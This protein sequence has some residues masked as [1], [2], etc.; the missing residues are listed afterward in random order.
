MKWPHLS[1]PLAFTLI[2]SYQIF[3]GQYNIEQFVF[4]AP[5]T[6]FFSANREGILSLIGHFSMQL[7]GVGMG[8][9]LYME[10]LDPRHFKALKANKTIRAKDA[11]SRKEGNAGKERKLILKVVACEILICLAYLASKDVFGQPSRRLCNLPYVLYQVAL[12]N[13]YTCYL[14]LIDRLLVARHTNMVDNAINYGQL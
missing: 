7:I 11:M 5:R 12:I 3:I 9:L 8:R 2:L 13:S 14:L 10:M 6:D 1:I 4:F